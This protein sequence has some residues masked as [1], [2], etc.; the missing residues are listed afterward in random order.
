M[1]SLDAFVESLI[2][3]QSWYIGSNGS[4]S[5]LQESSTLDD[6]IKHCAR[7]REAQK[8]GDQNHSFEAKGESYTF[9]WS[10]R[11]QEKEEIREY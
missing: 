2:Q 11:F 3:D 4:D 10:L 1:P 8:E 9:Q 7:K 6:I 5:N